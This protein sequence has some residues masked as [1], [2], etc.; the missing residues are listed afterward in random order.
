MLFLEKHDWR[1]APVVE[2]F[3]PGSMASVLGHEQVWGEIENGKSQ[4]MLL[5]RLY[6]PVD[7]NRYGRC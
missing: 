4:Q 3:R 2:R 1:P 5:E 7:R 6:G